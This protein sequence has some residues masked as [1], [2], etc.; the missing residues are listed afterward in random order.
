MGKKEFIPSEWL[1]K[2]KQNMVEPV[3]LQKNVLPDNGQLEKVILEIEAKNLDIASAYADWRDIGF[4]FA[5]AFGESGREYFHRISRFYSDYTATDCDAQFNKCLEANGT[6]ITLATFFFH[7]KQAGIKL[8]PTEYKE[9]VQREVL[10]TLGQKV[11][12]NLPEFLKSV[13]NIAKSDEEKDLLI[14]GS[15][16]S[17]SACLHKLYGIYDG[18]KVF[19]NLYLFITAQASAGKG[20]LLHCKQL[21]K[22]VHLHLREQAKMLKQQ[23]D[24]QMLDY[25]QAKG[26]DANIEKPNKPPEKMLFIPANNSTTGV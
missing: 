4:A 8:I 20:R 16:V 7:A 6:G 13:I 17:L 19:A 9:E 22:P 21:V 11:Y 12:D 1:E 14:L 10:P 18:K 25:N 15:I 2:P 3:Q 5:D 24:M 26:K 23:Y